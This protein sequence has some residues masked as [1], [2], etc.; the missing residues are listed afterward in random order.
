MYEKNKTVLRTAV[1]VDSSFGYSHIP[2][3]QRLK[4]YRSFHVDTKTR[5]LQN[6]FSAVKTISLDIFFKI[7]HAGHALVFIGDFILKVYLVL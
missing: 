6:S 1:T 7:P 5:I 4:Q 2:V 3:I